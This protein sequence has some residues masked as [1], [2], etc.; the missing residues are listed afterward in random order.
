MR[1]LKKEALL[2]GKQ[3][4]LWALLVIVILAGYLGHIGYPYYETWHN[5]WRLLN[6]IRFDDPAVEYAAHSLLWKSMVVHMTGNVMNVITVVLLLGVSMGLDLHRRRTEGMCFCGANPRSLYVRNFLM[7]FVLALILTVIPMGF[8]LRR[9]KDLF[10]GC[11]SFEDILFFVKPF[12]R[13]IL[14]ILLYLS[15][16]MLTCV[17]FSRKHYL[18][19]VGMSFVFCGA[20]SV[21]QHIAAVGIATGIGGSG[22][23]KNPLAY[24]FVGVDTS[25]LDRDY[26]LPP[27]NEAAMQAYGITLFILDAVLAVLFLVVGAVLFIRMQKKHLAEN[28]K[29]LSDIQLAVQAK[30]DIRKQGEEGIVYYIVDKTLPEASPL[31]G[32]LPGQGYGIF[33]KRVG[34]SR[35]EAK[36]Q[37][38]QGEKCLYY[39]RLDI[40]DNMKVMQLQQKGTDALQVQNYVEEVGL[41]GQ[42]ERLKELRIY[43]PDMLLCYELA[44]MRLSGV[45]ALMPDT[46]VDGTDLEGR[47]LV[48]AA[49]LR[50]KQT[51]TAL[52]L[53]GRNVED[54]YAAV[55]YFL[56]YKNEKLMEIV[57]KEQL[58]QEANLSIR[59][60]TD[61]KKRTKQ[62]LNNLLPEEYQYQEEDD[63]YTIFSH[64]IT[65]ELLREKLESVGV[66]IRSLE[67]KGQNVQEVFQKYLS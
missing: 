6:D 28:Q 60:Q 9:M 22:M 1:L 3:Y 14:D 31:A 15:L 18:L 7:V 17:L 38:E 51:G 42:N 58:E 63:T 47:N 67:W 55:D 49:A 56:V 13:H 20:L 11:F 40:W 57:S 32:Q 64:T 24:Y 52:F 26:V 30:R 4:T 29:P 2:W 19:G 25:I 53:K 5:H 61:D 46:T 43:T 12:L 66:K 23:N 27:G 33:Q 44:A 35:G 62:V 41:D 39:A 59:L 10:A 54:L 65:E 8:I 21:L 36:S 34:E 48:R 50:I 16:G 37:K 45:K